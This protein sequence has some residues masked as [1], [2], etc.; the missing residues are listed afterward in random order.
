M[1][2]FFLSIKYLFSGRKERMI[3]LTGGISVLGLALG[4]AS[5]IVVLSIMNGFDSEI[6]E[7]IIGTYSHVMVTAD[8]GIYNSD[9]LV[10]RL[11][12]EPEIVSAA[13][14]VTG[15]AVLRARDT[16]TGIIVKGIDPDKEIAVTDVITYSGEAASKLGSG[17]IVLGGELMKNERL[18]PGETVE[19]VLPYSVLDV[20]KVK[21]EV[22][23]SFTSGRYDYDSN[24]GIVDIGTAQKM[25]RMKDAITGVGMKIEDG[26]RANAVRDALRA[27]L[28]YPYAVRSWMDLDRNLVMA[29]AMEKKI[30]FIILTIIILVACFNIASSLIMTVMEKTRDIGILKAIGANSRGIKIVFVTLGVFIGALGTAVGAFLGVYIS[31]RVN[32]IAGYIENVTGVTLFPGDVYYFTEIPVKICRSDVI[33]VVAVAAALTLAAGMYPAWK[34]ARLDPVEAIRYE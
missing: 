30:M 4:V 8:G 24:I 6:R 1:W 31:R 20:E 7:K 22:V 27:D 29:L 32:V 34:A 13:P 3:S 15:Q 5:L 21:L 19:L 23:G 11:E 17:T 12:A 14:F 2:T 33:T 28:G 10:S 9:G 16:L 25:F 18:F 26:M